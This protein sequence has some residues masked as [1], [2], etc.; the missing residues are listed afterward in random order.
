MPREGWLVMNKKNAVV[1]GSNRGLGKSI[2]T[3]L[4]ENGYNVWA[5]A[6]KPNEDFEKYVIELA[7][8][9]HVWV[10]PVYFELTDYEQ[11]KNAYRSMIKKEKQIDVLVNN[12]GIGHMRLLQMTTSKEIQDI[13]QV[14]VLAPIYLSQMVLQNM[15]RQNSGRIINI[16]ST[17]ANEIY[18]GNSIYGSSKAALVAFTQSFAPEAYKYGVTVNAIAPGLLDTEMSSVIEG[19]DPEEPLRHTALGRKIDP[20]EVAEIVVELL[21]DKMQ[22]INGGVINVSGGHKDML[23]R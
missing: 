4:A 22:I 14:N 15:R 8:K 9:F 17:A 10:E 2:M 3:K 11:I 20:E 1:T 16:A 6:R 19:N 7:E 13:Y 23:I 21:S 18:E 12:A 5:C